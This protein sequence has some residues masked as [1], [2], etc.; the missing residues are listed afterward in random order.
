M[1]PT[2]I[3]RLGLYIALLTV[4]LAAGLL[5][6]ARGEDARVVAD[7]GTE[8][9]ASPSGL[10]VSIEPGSLAVSVIGTMLREL[11]ITWC[12]GGPWTGS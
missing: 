12:A 2:A 8:V 10:E 9:P 11:T 1:F 6:L 7:G 5:I 3:G 4:L